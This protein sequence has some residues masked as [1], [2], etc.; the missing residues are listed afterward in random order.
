MQKLSEAAIMLDWL[1]Y[2]FLMHGPHRIVCNPYTRFGTWCLRHAGA[3][4][5]RDHNLGDGGGDQ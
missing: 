3:W 5:Y 2:Q 4:A 1:G